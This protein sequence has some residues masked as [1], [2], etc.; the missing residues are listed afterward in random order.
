MAEKWKAVTEVSEVTP[1]ILETAQDIYE[2]FWANEPKID[3]IAFLERLEI[4]LEIDLGSQMD[5]GAIKTI[6]KHI[7]KFRKEN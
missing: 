5:S 3:W 7:Q 6:K 2:G 4:W 1:E